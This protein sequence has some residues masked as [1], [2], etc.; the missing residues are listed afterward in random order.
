M[1][2]GLDAVGSVSCHA[3]MLL[4]FTCRCFPHP[5]M[6]S[7]RFLALP[8]S[9]SA[10]TVALLLRRDASALVAQFAAALIENVQQIKPD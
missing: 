6:P 4:L 10:S 1:L 2:M 7:I 8:E 5:R 9:Q 3:F